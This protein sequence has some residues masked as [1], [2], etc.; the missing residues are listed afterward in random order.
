[1]SENGKEDWKPPFHRD[2]PRPS[3]PLVS[4]RTWMIGGAAFIGLAALFASSRESDEQRMERTIDE[5]RRALLGILQNVYDEMV[6]NGQF[7]TGIRPEELNDSVRAYALVHAHQELVGSFSFARRH[8]ILRS[9]DPRVVYDQY[10]RT[11]AQWNLLERD[12]RVYLKN[13][14]DIAVNMY[15]R[16]GKEIPPVLVDNSYPGGPACIYEPVTKK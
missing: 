3:G 2:E 12:Y 13:G 5:D 1:M 4:R 10:R 15:Q 14:I 9:P 11:R 7:P 8:N 16:Q 6:A